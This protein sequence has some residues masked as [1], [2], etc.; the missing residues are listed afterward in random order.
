[1]TAPESDDEELELLRTEA[2]TALDEHIKQIR[3]TDKKALK[4]L[5]SVALLLSVTVATLS[6]AQRISPEQESLAG[7]QNFFGFPSLLGI[8]FFVLAT[9]SAGITFTS[10][11]FRSGINPRE[12]KQLRTQK[13]DTELLMIKR[14]EHWIETTKEE[15][16]ANNFY[17]GITVLFLSIGILGIAYDISAGLFSETSKPVIISLF[18][19]IMFLNLYR[20]YPTLIEWMEWSHPKISAFIQQNFLIHVR[21]RRGIS[22]KTLQKEAENNKETQS[23]DN[24]N[25]NVYEQAPAH[26]NT[27]SHVHEENRSEYPI[28]EIRGE[29]I[30]SLV[31]SNPEIIEEGLEKLTTEK[32][33][34]KRP[35]DLV[36]EDSK[37]RK[38][39]IK[40]KENPSPKDV[41]YLRDLTKEFEKSQ[42]QSVRGILV[43]TYI[44][45]QVEE[46]LR[47]EGIEYKEISLHDRIS[48]ATISK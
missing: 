31:K 48:G 36:G 35:I 10:S 21:F 43:S 17:L 2:R 20:L 3:S 34:S 22:E 32:K 47:E 5:R 11:S 38:V 7:L 13:E 9:A 8:I 6:V 15:Q 19:L 37:G 1:M 42:N 28:K 18:L 23:G 30:E 45:K 46:Q 27:T 25:K 14:Y 29:D 44:P 26:S 39:I 12:L 16:I 40:T 41:Y 33:M 24:I 4:I